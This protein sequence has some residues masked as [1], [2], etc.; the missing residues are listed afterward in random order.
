MAAAV[1]DYR[2][3]EPSSAKVKKSELSWNLPLARTEDIL[4]E[5]SLRRDEGTLL[6]GF[7]LETEQLEEN[8][9]AKL[10]VKG[11]TGSWRTR[12]SRRARGSA[13]A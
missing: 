7:A 3:A 10:R 11:L 4:Q 5:V 1:G 6:V 2:V 9:R 8:A 12:R 13:R